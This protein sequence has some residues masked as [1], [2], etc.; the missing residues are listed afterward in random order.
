M[1]SILFL[2]YLI[3]LM[4]SIMQETLLCGCTVM[5]ANLYVYVAT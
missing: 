5:A 3:T 1:Q 4:F 2:L